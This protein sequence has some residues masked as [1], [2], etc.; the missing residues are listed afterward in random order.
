MHI[1]ARDLTFT[2]EP[3]GWF[4]AEFDIIAITFG[5]NGVVVDEVR[6][7]HTVRT[8]GETYQRIL[9][10][11]FVYNLTVP[12]KK[13]GA[14]QLRTALRDEGSSRIGSASQ[15]VEVPDIKKNR[16]L[17]SGIVVRGLSPESYKKRQS[18][19]TNQESSSPG[20]SDEVDAAASAAVRQ[21]SR[22]QVM[23]YAFFIYN[24][25]VEKVS[26]KPNLKSQLLLFRNGERVFTGNEVPVNM[27]DQPD[28][29]RL[30]AA[31]AL[32]LGTD[33]LPG[34]YAL[35]ILVTDPLAKEKQR[36]ASQWIDFEIIK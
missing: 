7:T 35:Q 13:P 34:E 29:R 9:K 12:I 23:E 5:D 22:G 17:I 1:R 21:F 10:D 27:L 6:K 28:L 11:G 18:G 26:G 3:D 24:S 36:V 14:Y 2:P 32:Q 25:R 8:K 4:K 19:L 16:L 30:A 20:Q 33:M 31:G 15:F